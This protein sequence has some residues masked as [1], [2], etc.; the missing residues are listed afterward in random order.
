MPPEHLNAS[1]QAEKMLR[2]EQSYCAVAQNLIAT[3]SKNN[4]GSGSVPLLITETT[5]KHIILHQLY[6][7]CRSPAFIIDVFEL[8]EFAMANGRSKSHDPRGKVHL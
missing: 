4:T 6:C 1:S 8:I 5:V 3:L 2:A 7:C